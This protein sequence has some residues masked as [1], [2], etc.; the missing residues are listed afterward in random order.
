MGE[1]AENVERAR[2]PRPTRKPG[3]TA[4]EFRDRLKAAGLTTRAAAKVLGASRSA[5]SRWALGHRPIP[6]PVAKLLYF[7]VPKEIPA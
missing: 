4:E 2:R 6:S 5:V 7:V 3:M 1:G